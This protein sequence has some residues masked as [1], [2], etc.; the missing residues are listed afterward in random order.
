MSR[1]TLLAGLGALA[2]LA[3]SSSAFARGDEIPSVYPAAPERA[4]VSA[5]LS[6]LPRGVTAAPP[7]FDGGLFVA[8]VEED[9][10]P[11][12]AT[13]DVLAALGEILPALGVEIDPAELSVEVEGERAPGPD[14]DALEVEGELEVKVWQEEVEREVGPLDADTYAALEEETLDLAN[15]LSDTVQIWR[16][17]QQIGRARAVGRSVLVQVD[18]HGIRRI[19]GALFN[20]TAVEDTL[21]I[22]AERAIALAEAA[23]SAI[24]GSVPDAPELVALPDGDLIRQAWQMTVETTAGPYRVAVETARGGILAL[25][26]EFYSITDASG[27]VVEPTLPFTT[28]VFGFEVNDVAKPSD[29]TYTLNLDGQ[30]AL[31]NAGADG[32]T[33]DVS[34]CADA[35][36]DADF[37]VLPI[38]VTSNITNATL[39]TYNPMFAHVNAFAWVT[40]ALDYYESRGSGNLPAWDLTVNDDVVCGFGIDNACGWLGGLSLGLGSAT[41]D[42]AG[43]FFN[44]ALDASIILHEVGHGVNNKRYAEGGGTQNGSCAEGLSDYWA[45]SR[46]SNPLIGGPTAGTTTDVETGWL[47]RAADAVD[48]FPEHVSSF[49]EVHANGQVIARALWATRAEMRGRNPFGG[50]FA[51]TFLMAV[52]PSAGQGQAGDQSEWS[53]H[54][55]FQGILLSMLV[56]AQGDARPDVLVGFAQAGLMLTENEAVIDISSDILNGDS[57]AA[58]MFQVWTGR[59]FGFTGTTSNSDTFYNTHYEIEVAN[60]AAFAKNLASSGDQN[61]V[62]I[63]NGVATAVWSLSKTDWDKLRKGSELYFRV[64]T[65]NDAGDWDSVRTS[66]HCYGEFFEVNPGKALI[67]HSGGIACSAVPGRAAGWAGLLMGLAAALRRRR[68]G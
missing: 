53:V 39:W 28:N 60:D 50:M 47:P 38:N 15:R 7:A 59:D 57:T 45:F 56:E 41:R 30:I 12:R 9:V 16:F 40:D 43:V 24:R 4:E 65:W 42:G 27:A 33:D 6:R 21:N 34:A 31:T 2:S 29:C 25:E 26:P 46:L 11:V 14:L 48:V 18:S 5:A 36:G 63:S 68:R 13:E 17:Q 64:T 19:S 37:N 8:E 1:F 66:T 51:D 35:S 49:N 3:L 62:A 52:L 67:N 22:D 23:L 10:Y 55:A 58:P 54:N 20:D 61:N 32:Y 44:T